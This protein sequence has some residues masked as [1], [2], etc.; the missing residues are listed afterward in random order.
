MMACVL[1]PNLLV[2]QPPLILTRGFA[3]TNGRSEVVCVGVGCC[4]R[5]KLLGYGGAW[6]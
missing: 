6:S 2:F 4:I 3:D 1:T 5:E